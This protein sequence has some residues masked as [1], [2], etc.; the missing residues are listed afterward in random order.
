MSHSGIQQSC[1]LLIC[2]IRGWFKRI[3]GLKCY[4]MAPVVGSI[5][6]YVFSCGNAQIGLTYLMALRSVFLRKDYRIFTEMLSFSGIKSDITAGNSAAGEFTVHQQAG[7]TTHGS[8]KWNQQD[9]WQKWVNPPD[10]PPQ[11]TTAHQAFQATNYWSF[12]LVKLQSVSWIMTQ[13]LHKWIVDPTMTSIL[14]IHT[15]FIQNLYGYKSMK[16]MHAKQKCVEITVV[17]LI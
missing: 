7:E 10:L 3:S 1:I 13:E 5:L 2:Q 17:T 9:P 12:L 11:H 4:R 6:F 8:D 16:S 15:H 14:F